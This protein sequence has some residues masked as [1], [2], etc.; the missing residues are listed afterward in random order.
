MIWLAIFVSMILHELAH[1]A[2]AVRF[3][4]TAPLRF[5]RLSI[6]PL[7]HISLGWTIVLPLVTYLLS[8]GAFVFG[9]MKPIPIT[10]RWLT[11]NQRFAVAAA[12][13][14]AN[15]VIAIAMLHVWRE[16]ALVNLML[17]IVN[18]LPIPPLDGWRMIKESTSHAA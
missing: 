7:N 1:A 2:L 17:A 11:P 5:G 4:D 16:A 15:V 3:G 9:S 18:L 12:G 13:P 6:D 14:A 8:H 10:Y